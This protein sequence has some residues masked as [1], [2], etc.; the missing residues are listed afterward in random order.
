VTLTEGGRGGCHC[1]FS[2]F[3]FEKLSIFTKGG[4]WELFSGFSIACK[5]TT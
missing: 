1:S 4:T 5:T 3:L 2:F